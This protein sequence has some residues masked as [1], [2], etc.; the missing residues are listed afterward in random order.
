MVL[1]RFET[2][3]A[4]AQ[5]SASGRQQTLDTT[6]V[7]VLERHPSADV[8]TVTFMPQIETPGVTLALPS[9]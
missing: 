3:I 8:S 6:Q 2:I 7:K 1:L 5:Q 9:T 4:L